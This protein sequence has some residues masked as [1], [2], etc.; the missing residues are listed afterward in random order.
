MPRGR[1]LG[2]GGGGGELS[3]GSAAGKG[4]CDVN[5][6]KI[7][8][9]FVVS[10]SGGRSSAY[11]LR[12]VLDAWG[13]SLPVDGHVFFANTGREFDGTLD[14]V[15]EI[16][17]RWNVPIRWIQR[18]PGPHLTKKVWERFENVTYETAAREG[19]PFE[20]LILDR[21]FLP[22]PVKR[23]CTSEL[24][25]RPMK[26]AMVT[27]GY[28]RWT[29]IVGI[30]FDEPVRVAKIRGSRRRQ[31]WTVA[32]PLVDARVRKTDV[33]RFFREHPFDLKL[34]GE[35]EGNCDLCFLKSLESRL[36]VLRESPRRGDWWERMEA[37]GIGSTP[38]SRVFRKDQ[39]PVRKLRVI[40]SQS[41][42]G[43]F[44]FAEGG[45]LPCLCTD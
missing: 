19:E 23:I 32:L 43:D 30:R 13:G 38:R 9:P 40:A 33:L 44:D 7:E 29:N 15:R 1:A 31:R 10:L 28:K 25:I 5:P 45:G 11:M 27:L 17:E 16:G 34:K 20:R 14:F 12:C 2:A 4:W 42:Q 18:A 41:V 26:S 6:Y 35:H 22:N 21:R 36:R 3:K 24:K 37:L 39:P 8:P